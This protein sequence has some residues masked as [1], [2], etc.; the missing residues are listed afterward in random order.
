LALCS[1]SVSA[2]I[3]VKIGGTIANATEKSISLARIESFEGPE[4]KE[5]DE[6]KI[7]NGK[8]QK[9]V[10]LPEVGVCLLKVGEKSIILML[11]GNENINLKIDFNKTPFYEVSGSQGSEL[12]R[13]YILENDK[14]SQEKIKP[15]EEKF[16]KAS[17]DEEKEAIIADFMNAQ[18]E[19]RKKMNS[20]ALQ[21]FGSSIA[22]FMLT[23]EWDDD[24]DLAYI[25]EIN[26]RF[27]A[28]F[29]GA[30]VAN[31]V[32]NLADNYKKFA[33]GSVAPDI[34]L[35]TPEGKNIKLSS[36]RGKY[37]LLDFW[38]AWCAPCRAENPNVVKAYEQFKNKGFT[39]YGV[40]LDED[41]DKWTKAI[42]KD[43]LNWTNVS[44]LQGWNNVAARAY[45]ITAIPKNFLLDKEG[46]IIAKNLR[47]SALEAKLKELMP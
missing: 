31:Y 24:T 16:K 47:G 14:M 18:N 26:K 4:I 10:S 46:R 28:K 13:A 3:Q 19:I 5:F 12:V 7:Q 6:I 25:D 8:F 1:L 23:L 33:I 20:W 39:I 9:N 44:D 38:A 11:E 45:G 41:K 22:L 36:L 21:K 27:Q 43:G 29:K 42:A 32:A 35:P 34:E 15:L 2:Q 30:K 40:S 37:V 17:S